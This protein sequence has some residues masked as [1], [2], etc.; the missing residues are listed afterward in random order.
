MAA[1]DV[2][3]WDLLQ[4]ASRSD[5]VV[6]RRQ[7]L[8]AGITDRRIDGLVRRRLL[9]RVL[10]GVYAVATPALPWRGV[11]RAAALYAGPG[12]FVTGQ[13]GLALRDLVH[14]GQ[15][16]VV[17][18]PRR[19]EPRRVTIPVRDGRRTWLRFIRCA[20]PVDG[21][22]RVQGIPTSTLAR[23]FV[24][25]ARTVN[26]PVLLRAW[27]EATFRCLIDVAEFERALR[28]SPTRPGSAQIR[29][30][31]RTYPPATR[32]G[33]DIRSRAGELAFLEIVSEAG[34]P[35][36]LVNAR[37]RLG[38]HEFVADFLFVDLGLVVE[39]DGGQHD[40][41]EDKIRDAIF[42]AHGLQVL[43]FDNARIRA[44]RAWVRQTLLDTVSA[45]AALRGGTTSGGERSWQLVH[46][47]GG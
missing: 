39:T 4:L 8:R 44:D 17:G 7:L 37:L 15:H 13:A 2:D 16:V 1:H 42:A 18:G 32:P 46:R 33:M 28:A 12:A 23:S 24:D 34:L 30:L 3:L 41:A 43:R 27:R 38:V 36:P 45:R 29:E 19:L 14:P 21:I 20:F 47:T 9:T 5:G 31:L 22:D 35:T 11:A 25:A 26:R 6:A 40:A 10:P